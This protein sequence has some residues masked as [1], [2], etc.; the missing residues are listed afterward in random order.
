[1]YRHIGLTVRHKLK[2][3]EFLRQWLHSRNVSDLLRYMKPKAWA[4]AI[5][6]S[7]AKE[8]VSLGNQ[9]HSC[10]SSSSK[11]RPEEHAIL[12]RMERKRAM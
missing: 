12:A 4:S 5:S 10:G 7:K 11:S 2:K 6:I 8:T 9:S 1:M 3:I